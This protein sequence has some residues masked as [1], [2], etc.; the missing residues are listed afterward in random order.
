M[1]DGTEVKLKP[2]TVETMKAGSYV[3]FEDLD[4]FFKDEFNP[5]FDAYK[6]AYPERNVDKGT[7]NLVFEVTET[8]KEH[9]KVEDLW[10][11]MVQPVAFFVPQYTSVAEFE[12][13]VGL[14][15]IPFGESEVPFE[16]TDLFVRIPKVRV[17]GKKTPTKNPI[18]H[19]KAFHVEDV[20]A[21]ADRAGVK[22]DNNKAFM[23]L[24]ERLTGKRHLDD[25]NEKELR[26]VA[27]YLGKKPIRQSQ[28]RSNL[29][30]V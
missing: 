16:E 23:D 25:M 8:A 10:V 9:D 21:A 30:F 27:N 2:G 26:F 6:A 4:E 19:T 22:W 11:T 1:M 5:L 14:E 24:T 7:E 12:G 18:P 28:Q 17:V 3:L 15:D 20:H 29:T 13:E